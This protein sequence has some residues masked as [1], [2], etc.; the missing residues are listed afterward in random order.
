MVLLSINVIMTYIYIKVVI[1]SVLVISSIGYILFNFVDQVNKN[2]LRLCC[3]FNIIVIINT[4]G[5]PL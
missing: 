3:I 2:F 4:T 5:C 1:I